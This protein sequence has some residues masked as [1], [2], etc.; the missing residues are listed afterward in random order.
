MREMFNLLMIKRFTPNQENSFDDLNT[1]N[2][3]NQ[4]Y[5]VQVSSYTKSQRIQKNYQPLLRTEVLAKMRQKKVTLIITTKLL[6]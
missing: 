3:Q 2:T 4:F 1:M 5:Q 6:A